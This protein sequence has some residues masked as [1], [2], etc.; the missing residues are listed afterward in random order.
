VAGPEFFNRG[1]GSVY[2]QKMPTFFDHTVQD[3]VI[4]H[5]KLRVSTGEVALRLMFAL[6]SNDNK[7]GLKKP[8]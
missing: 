4:I 8:Y 5:K 1:G 2:R 6:P 7:Y 3:T